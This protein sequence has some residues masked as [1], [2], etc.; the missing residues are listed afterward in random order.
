VSAFPIIAR[1]DRSAPVVALV[2]RF[3]DPLDAEPRDRAG[4]ASVADR[5]FLRGAGGL[6]RERFAERLDDLGVR[7]W[8]SVDHDALIG[9]IQAPA[10]SFEDALE[11]LRLALTE[12]AFAPDELEKA[13]AEAVAAIEAIEDDGFAIAARELHAALYGEE[14]YGRPEEGTIAGVRAVTRENLLA[15][16]KDVVR[17]DR[18]VVAVAGDVAPDAAREAVERAFRGLESVREKRYPNIASENVRG[19]P[20]VSRAPDRFVQKPKEQICFRLGH[21]GIAPTHPEWI[22][23]ALAMKHLSSKVFFRFVYENG[24]AYRAWTYLSGGRRPRPFTFEMG[25]SGP[26][27]R[28]ALDGL[29]S[30]LADLVARGLDAADLEKAK[31]EIAVRHALNQQTNYAQASLLAHYEAVGVG[32]RRVDELP[33]LAAATPLDAVNEAIRRHLHPDALTLAATGDLAAAEAA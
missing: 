23:L 2:A 7:V 19:G 1:E 26:S 24:M 6:S 29:R 28:K 4:L 20:P 9:G 22:A 12:P 31:S 17:A 13:R 18:L 10:P 11:A 33:A 8:T 21:V 3:A 16:R 27:Y 32:W 30:L 5:L 15:W 25:V 14:G